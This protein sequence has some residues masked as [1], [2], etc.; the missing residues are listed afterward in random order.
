MKFL[1]SLK[2]AKN[3]KEKEKKAKAVKKFAAAA[4]LG[5]AVGAVTGLLFAPK[6]GKE[7]RQDIA[8]NVKEAS[9]SV[10][11]SANNVKEKAA[12]IQ[13]GLKGIWGNVSK[14]FTKDSGK[15]VETEDAMQE[16]QPA[17]KE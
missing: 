12:G 9:E 17:E 3:K 14:F 2:D 1:K 10:K 16:E 13:N 7:T 11:D 15:N 4:T 6:A 5:S 8:N